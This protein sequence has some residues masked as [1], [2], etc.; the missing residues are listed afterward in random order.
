M[1]C[2]SWWCGGQPVPLARVPVGTRVMLPCGCAVERREMALPGTDG[3]ADQVPV[4]FSS[5]MCDLH[6]SAAPP[7]LPPEMLVQIDL[8][9]SLIDEAR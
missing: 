2:Q 9:A 8:L 3:T 5:A 7:V 4:V 6:R 1:S